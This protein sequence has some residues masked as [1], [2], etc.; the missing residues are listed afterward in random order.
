MVLEAPCS[1]SSCRSPT[2]RSYSLL[3]HCSLMKEKVAR[4]P[5][6]SGLGKLRCSVGLTPAAIDRPAFLIGRVRNV[7]S[8]QIE[9]SSPAPSQNPSLPPPISSLD[10]TKPPPQRCPPRTRSCCGLWARFREAFREVPG[11]QPGIFSNW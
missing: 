3:L 6:P 5:R 4:D 10:A 11:C 7:S 2:K 1:P 9:R 8:P